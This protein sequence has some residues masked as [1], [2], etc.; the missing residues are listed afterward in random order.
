MG[1]GNSSQTCRGRGEITRQMNEILKAGNKAG[2]EFSILFAEKR[3]KIS[4]E[5]HL[6]SV[7][8]EAI[9]TQKL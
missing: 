9:L 3:I 7:I 2:R 1:Q 5:R 4:C 8:S 6:E